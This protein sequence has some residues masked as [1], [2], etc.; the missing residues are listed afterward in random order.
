MPAHVAL[1]PPPVAASRRSPTATSLPKLL[2]GYAVGGLC[3]AGGRVLCVRGRPRAGHWVHCGVHIFA[4][5]GNLLILPY[6]PLVV[7]V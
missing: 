3:Y 2:G 7:R 1:K 4:N 6:V 5:L